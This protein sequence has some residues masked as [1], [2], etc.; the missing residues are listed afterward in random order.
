MPDGRGVF[1]LCGPTASGKTAFGMDLAKAIPDIV[2]VNADT[3][4]LY[5]GLEPLAAH[6]S[7]ADMAR[8]EHRMF[9]V[10]SPREPFGR[11]QWLSMAMGETDRI[12]D[13][14]KI[15][16][17]VGGSRS[18]AAE[19]ARAAWDVD[20]PMDQRVAPT[21]QAEDTAPQPHAAWRGMRLISVMRTVGDLEGRVRSRLAANR[22]AAIRC[23]GKMLATL[24]DDLDHAALW[25]LGFDE[26][27]ACLGG[28][29]GLDEA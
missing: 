29:M 25:T 27:R 15:P 26:L 20:L 9:G 3:M 12:L 8:A 5:R 28:R 4:Q 11:R 23:V 16:V 21:F 10:L 13:R 2:F 7:S 24:G 19:L 1:Y 22:Q 14:G 17:L 18:L 6:P